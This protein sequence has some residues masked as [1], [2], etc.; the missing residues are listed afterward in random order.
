MAT[1]SGARTR[2]ST[3]G[4]TCRS[5]G[6][7][8]TCASTPGPTCRPKGEDAGEKSCKH[9]ARDVLRAGFL[10]KVFGLL[11]AQMVFTIVFAAA[12][13]FTPS[14]RNT[15]LV[16]AES[17]M[18]YLQMACFIPT[19]ASLLILQLGAKRTYPWNYILLFVFTVGTSIDIGYICA[20]FHA[21]G[22]GIL[23]LQAFAA[24]A[25]IFC[26]LT[27]YAFV[28]GRNFSFF[29]GFLSVMLWGLFLTGL[30]GF[31]FPWMVQSL[32]YG[33]VGALTFCAYILYD[34]W[35]IQHKFSYDDYIGATLELYLDIVNLFLYILKI[36]SKL[37]KSKKKKK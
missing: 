19:F 30:G 24:T 33:L 31:F 15:F 22:H 12:C 13:M 20:V 11:A 29:G 36:L 28:S 25:V 1:K 6:E 2:A 7:A 21:T 14:I 32:L 26:A 3:P 5:K 17:K 16:L 18:W 9:I 34:V 8:R 37:D 23:V 35:R 10:R 27:A 4:P